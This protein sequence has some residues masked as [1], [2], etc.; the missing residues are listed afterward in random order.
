MDN[1][2][3]LTAP[4]E[5]AALAAR[6][7][8]GAQSGPTDLVQLA[9]AQAGLHAARLITPYVTA[10]ARLDGF[11]PDQLRSA[12]APGG[13]L[14]KM[15]CMRRTL[16][17][18]PLDQAGDAHAA[19]LRLRLGATAA[20]AQRHHL[21]STDLARW[22]ESSA[23]ELQTGPLSYRDLQERMSKQHPRAT[24]QGIRLG[25][26]WAWESGRITCLN[27]ATSL[28]REARHFALLTHAH[29]GLSLT[30]EDPHA[31]T[32]RLVRR[33][34][35]AYGPTSQGDLLWW[36]GLPRTQIAPALAALRQ[37]ITL[38]RVEGLDMEQMALSRDIDQLRASQPLPDDHV[39]L[40]AFEDPSLKGYFTTRPRYHE[41]AHTARAFN[42]I[43]EVRATI[44]VAG[45]IAGTWAWDKRSRTIQHELFA[46]PPQ[47]VMRL[48]HLQLERTQA[49]LRG[50]PC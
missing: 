8:W 43:G 18:W 21:S 33:Y 28:H 41:P 35:H 5:R 50:E 29:P 24:V 25:I 31:A 2:V 36:S 16:H 40:L 34:L 38:V 48:I 17:L 32:I 20:T 15:R 23:N 46:R 37:E 22:A 7:G 49:F 45:R 44:T 12:L 1:P 9:R 6:H 14:V 47:H 27:A 19:T 3:M 26:K 39:R 4:A 13:G 30:G 42:P 10:H 11:R